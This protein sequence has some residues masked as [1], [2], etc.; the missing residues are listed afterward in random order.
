MYLKLQCNGATIQTV[1]RICGKIDSED[2]V[3]SL[4]EDPP[5]P[6]IFV[7]KE[8][9]TTANDKITIEE[10]DNE[11]QDMLDNLEDQVKDDPD[12]MATETTF[13]EPIEAES[14]SDADTNVAAE[15][16]PDVDSSLP[17]EL[18]LQIELVES[19][20]SENEET[21]NKNENGVDESAE[22]A[23][24]HGTNDYVTEETPVNE[25]NESQVPMKGPLKDAVNL[26][27]ISEVS[28]AQGPKTPPSEVAINKIDES[29]RSKKRPLEDTT[30]LTPVLKPVRQKPLGKNYQ[31]WQCLSWFVTKEELKT[32]SCLNEFNITGNVIYTC[33]F[34]ATCSD[35]IDQLRPHVAKC[36]MFNL[37]PLK[38]FLKFESAMTCTIGSVKETSS[39]S[40]RNKRNA[41]GTKDDNNRAQV[42]QDIKVIKLDR[43]K[44]NHQPAKC[45]KCNSLIQSYELLK[46][47][48][49]RPN[50]CG[51]CKTRFGTMCDL[52]QHT[53]SGPPVN[54]VPP[55]KRV[56]IKSEPGISSVLNPVVILKNVDRV[57]YPTATPALTIQYV[58]DAKVPVISDM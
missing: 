1:C 34:C 56:K 39:R 36:K 11:F 32:H 49:T 51:T 2:E 4:K 14:A 42:D 22:I 12:D 3:S 58:D 47:H 53:C 40:T 6:A 37:G 52:L 48:Q 26:A 28:E 18:P 19:V 20:Q 31:C 17:E 33:H 9:K 21:L 13:A 7:K 45:V 44:I 30:N 27:P 35:D 41:D 43:S 38:C 29:Q 5:I 50:F 57:K 54:I 10:L 16:S 23:D 25:L 15:K 8:P 55:A 24:T 46:A